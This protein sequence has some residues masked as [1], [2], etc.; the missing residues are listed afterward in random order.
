MKEHIGLEPIDAYYFLHNPFEC[1]KYFW[2]H[3]DLPW[4]S[5]ERIL[6]G[7]YV[8]FATD[9]SGRSTAKTTEYLKVNV[10][11]CMCISDRKALLLGQDKIIGIELF[12]EHLKKWL[13]KLSL[14]NE[15]CQSST[16]RGDARISHRDEGAYLSFL[17][18]SV[19]FTM[20]PDWSQAAH[21]LQSWRVNALIFNEWTTFCNNGSM[22]DMME[23]V[24]PIATRDN[25]EFSLTR[26]LREVSEG[27]IGEPLGLLSDAELAL[28]HRGEPDF[29]ARSGMKNSVPLNTFKEIKERFLDNFRHCYGFDYEEGLQHKELGL[30]P[31]GT[32]DDI[33]Y[34]FGIFLE[35]DPPYHNQIIYDGSAKRPSEESY[36][37]IEYV[38]KQLG[39]EVE[40]RIFYQDWLIDKKIRNHFFSYYSVSVD[41][42][43]KEYDGKIYSSAILNKYRNTHLEEDFRRLYGG[44][45]IEGV[46]KKPYDPA[47]IRELRVAVGDSRYFEV[48]LS[49]LDPNA[50]YMMAIDAASGTEASVK[51]LGNIRGSKGSPGD[52]GCSTIFKLGEG[53]VDNPHKLVNV[54]VANDIRPEPMAFDIQ[55]LSMR[56]PNIVW[57]LIDPG[58]G[59]TQLAETLKKTELEKDGEIREFTPVYPID[60]NGDPGCG[61]MKAIFISRGTEI[62][63][64]IHIQTGDEKAKW[65]GKDMMNHTI[66]TK[67]R[68]AIQN[69]TVLFPP[70]YDEYMI[71]DALKKKTITLEKAKLIDNVE[72]ALKQ[73]GRID[74]EVEKLTG[75]IKLTGNGVPTYKCRGRK[76]M[77]MTLVYGL[78]GMYVY[79]E[80]EKI[81]R[82]EEEGIGTIVLM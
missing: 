3:Q 24:E 29:I 50:K 75:K 26:K 25:D 8:P 36:R 32:V 17:N 77:A 33:R 13:V 52:D 59:G 73:L 49:Q 48:E 61:L 71:I 68:L 45:W 46:S 20:S 55:S 74:F 23:Q 30:K 79:Q 41:E 18:G 12:D 10:A 7:F 70:Y 51:G 67:A 82:A 80:W 56:F 72:I 69:K 19:F 5:K 78:Y 40:E 62:M 44:E 39:R 54:Y 76:D 28:M 4:T 81:F 31:I 57:M 15:Q 27:H 43:P 2:E 42:V 37:W 53:T 9:C 60:Y 22:E 66:H 58:G 47:E 1:I 64:L 21:K 34:F 38:N 11:K 63:K 65:A 14:I 16:G 6:Y 35:G